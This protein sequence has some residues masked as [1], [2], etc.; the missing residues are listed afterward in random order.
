MS[1]P[2]DLRDLV[3]DDVG[4]DELERLAQA[5]AALRVAPE[6]P[7]VSDSLTTRVRAIPVAGS[8]RSRRRL[9]AALPLA[10]AL[11]AGAFAIGI[12]V[13]G[14]P[15]PEIADQLTLSATPAAPEGARMVIAVLPV[16]PAG[17]WG[18]AADVS[19]LP[20]LPAG[21]YYEVGLTQGGEITAT[22]GRFVVDDDGTAT[23][24]WL[25]APYRFADYE[26]W[27]VTAHV[28]GREPSGWLL[29][30]PVYGLL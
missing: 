26:R 16:D 9:A 23:G 6:P 8:R 11:A 12:W 13:G 29:D 20:P 25:N 5:D 1:E 28:P 30:G 3:G 15:Q 27:V 24:V 18:M 10:A 22:C 14:D 17:N 19:G 2:R 21:G 7:H 4:W